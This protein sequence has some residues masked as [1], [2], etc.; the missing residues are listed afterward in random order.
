M[1][2]RIRE[3]IFGSHGETS[4]MNFRARN[5]A[6]KRTERMVQV[7]I[8]LT[9]DMDDNSNIVKVLQESD[10]DVVMPENATL[11]DAELTKIEIR[12]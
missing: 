5:R 9:M 11:I 3:T 7:T 1:F 12:K 4:K 2:D 8:N 10:I 6:T